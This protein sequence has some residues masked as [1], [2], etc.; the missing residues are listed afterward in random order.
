[1]DCLTSPR[2]DRVL[3]TG[4]PS[5]RRKT[6]ARMPRGGVPGSAMES[7]DDDNDA[8][9]SGRGDKRKMSTAKALCRMSDVLESSKRTK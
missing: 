9:S 2:T 7:D 8:G 6:G 4:P 5:Q 1:M 3:L